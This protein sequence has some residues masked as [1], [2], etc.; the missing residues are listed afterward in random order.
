MISFNMKQPS[1]QC[2]V[3]SSL[4]GIELESN[5]SLHIT[6]IERLFENCY[7]KHDKRYSK[8]I[9]SSS[10][11]D[12]LQRGYFII[13]SVARTIYILGNVDILQRVGIE[14]ILQRFGQSDR[15][16]TV[17]TFWFDANRRTEIS[18]KFQKYQIKV[19]D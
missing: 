1:F 18:V 17:T 4:L 5:T 15:L 9:C 8:I 14:N 6:L 16:P 3:S 10:V 12:S 13:G 11:T 19:F 7:I 2:A